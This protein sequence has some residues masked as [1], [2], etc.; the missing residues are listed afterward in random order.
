MN[1]VWHR[2]WLSLRVLSIS[3]L[4][5]RGIRDDLSAALPSCDIIPIT[6]RY[7]ELP[8]TPATADESLK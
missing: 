8:P 5:S 1:L 7:T 4:V 6:I 2:P 3:A